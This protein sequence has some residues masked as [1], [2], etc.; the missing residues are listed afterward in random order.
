MNQRIRVVAGMACLVACL[1]TV[2]GLPS[3]PLREAQARYQRAVKAARDEYRGL[4]LA[5][6]QAA[7]EEGSAGAATRLDV[8]IERL[9]VAAQAEQG[10]IK[11]RDYLP[12]PERDWTVRYTNGY[13]RHYV[14]HGDGTVEYGGNRM[15]MIFRPESFVLDFDD[16]KL[17]RWTPMADGGFHVDHY[18]PK[19][20]YP[21]EPPTCMGVAREER[22]DESR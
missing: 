8:E 19:G 1:T 13:T 17:E 16:G 6:R 3:A 2:G 15:E 7:T 21:E 5:A 14:F 22:R 9:S 20:R 10:T 11:Y 18:H 12:E 4:L